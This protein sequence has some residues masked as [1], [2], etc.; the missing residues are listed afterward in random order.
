MALLFS[1]VETLCSET[2]AV[3]SQRNCYCFRHVVLFCHNLSYHFMSLAIQD[4]LD[5]KV[6]LK[7]E[8]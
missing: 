3:Y 2:L 5:C 1:L 8:Y 6:V 7:S 4:F